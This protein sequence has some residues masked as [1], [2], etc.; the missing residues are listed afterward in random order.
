[1]STSAQKPR[2]RLDKKDVRKG[3][4][5]EV[6]AL[7]QHPM[8]SGQRKDPDGR[9]VPRKILH[10]FVCTLAGKQVFSADLEPA[11][12]ANPYIQFK[13]RAEQSGTVVLVWIDDDGSNIIGQEMLTVG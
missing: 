9:L 13:F 10:K 12:A 8:E 3:D 4:L 11:I 1:M 5:V 2:I 7:V 6:K